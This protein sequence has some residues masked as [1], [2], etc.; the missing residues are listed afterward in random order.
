MRLLAE[1]GDSKI[2]PRSRPRPAADGEDPDAARSRRM[3][4]VLVLVLEFE[5]VGV[6]RLKRPRKLKSDGVAGLGV[7]DKVDPWEQPPIVFV[8]FPVSFSEC[9]VLSGIGFLGL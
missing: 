7:E 5:L 4:L 9:S 3:V 2:S 6:A 8:A 1:R